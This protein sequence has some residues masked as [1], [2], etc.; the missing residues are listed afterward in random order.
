MF[1]SNHYNFPFRLNGNMNSFLQNISQL[2]DGF[3]G[4]LMW[5]IFALALDEIIN[6]I[7]INYVLIET[8]GLY[9]IP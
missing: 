7:S 5:M 6:S 2:E 8:I 1:F 9:F 3:Q 4:D